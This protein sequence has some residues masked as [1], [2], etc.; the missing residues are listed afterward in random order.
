MSRTMRAFMIAV[1]FLGA[2]CLGYLNAQTMQANEIIDKI[3]A[4]ESVDLRGVTID[5]DLDF[6]KLDNMKK[7]KTGGDRESFRS[8]VNVTLNFTD[9]RFQ[10]KVMGYENAANDNWRKQDEPVYHANFARD[11]T[12]VNCTFEDDA[13]FKYSEFFA[14]ASF[15]GAV[16]EDQA[17]FK[18][19]HFEEYVDFSGAKFEDDANFKYTELTE[20]VTFAGAQFRD[21]AIFKYTELRREVSFAGAKFYGEANFK[22][23]KFPSGTNLTNT[24]FGKDTDFKYATLG[25]KK[26]TR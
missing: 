4:G 1:I 18:Y 10:D 24:S 6:T 15:K 13:L 11:V 23:I 3:N 7:T 2:L 20:G 22:Y 17:L 5:G 19:T 16:F 21:D 12:F 9:C 14:D 8:T 25:G 26:F